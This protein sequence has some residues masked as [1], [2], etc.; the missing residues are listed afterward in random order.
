MY[1][2]GIAYK[3]EADSQVKMFKFKDQLQTFG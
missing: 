1:L 2:K 3:E